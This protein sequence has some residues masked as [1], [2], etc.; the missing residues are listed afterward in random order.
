MRAGV[1]VVDPATT[2]VD[3]DVVLEPGRRRCCPARSCTTAPGSPPGATVGPGHHAVRL[4]GRRRARRSSAATAAARSSA[5]GATVGPFAYLRPGTDLGEG[6]KI[7]TFVETKNARIG[8]GSK[9]PHLS[10]VGDAEIGEGS[11]IG[12]ASVFVNY[13]GTDQAPHR[14]RRPRP[15]RLGHHARRAARGGRRRLH[16]G[17][18]GGP[19]RRPARRAVD[20][21]RSPSASS[22]AGP[23][24]AA[25]APPS[26]LAAAPRRRHRQDAADRPRT[27]RSHARTDD[28]Q[29]HAMIGITS[30]PEKRLVLVSGRAHPE[31]AREVAAA[32]GRG[33][34]PHDRVRLRQR[35]DLRPL[36]RERPRLRRVRPA[37][38]HRAR[39][40]S[41]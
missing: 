37:V 7:G 26:A 40:T 6:G 1:T 23:R 3:V 34:R 14:G 22:R 25:P 2:W 39:S 17:R 11:N 15:D 18:V 20:V 19:Q 10:Y 4:H 35:R 12:A 28:P 31:L 24:A 16:R 30:T 13:D 21:A 5:P 38:P 27:D 32:L 41:G 33:H 8:A 29:E 9:V 36:R